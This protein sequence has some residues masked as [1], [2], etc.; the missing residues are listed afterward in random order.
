MELPEEKEREKGAEKICKEIMAI[1][2]P[3]LIK[4]KHIQIQ[5]VQQV[6]RSININVKYR[7]QYQNI[8]SNHQKP[9]RTVKAARKR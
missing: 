1:N 8:Q 7:R 2:F 3:H 9:K 5:E 4:D 6:P